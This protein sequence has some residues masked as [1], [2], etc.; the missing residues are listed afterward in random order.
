MPGKSRNV[1]ATLFTQYLQSRDVRI[2]NVRR[3]ADADPQAS[4][5]SLTDSGRICT[6]MLHT[7]TEEDLSSNTGPRAM[8]IVESYRKCNA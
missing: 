1:G 2:A 4:L 3:L 8:F 6:K 5:D 7:R